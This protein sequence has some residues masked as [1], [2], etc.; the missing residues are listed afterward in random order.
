MIQKLIAL[1]WLRILADKGNSNVI[2]TYYKSDDSTK[3]LTAC[4]PKTEKTALE[5]FTQIRLATNLV[6][7]F[8]SDTLDVVRSVALPVLNPCRYAFEVGNPTD[9]IFYFYGL[10]EST[11]PSTTPR[12]L[13]FNRLMRYSTPHF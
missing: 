1:P 12:P 3:E 9:F 8:I 13:L 5:R 10:D 2:L 6:D 4:S 11:S 7:G